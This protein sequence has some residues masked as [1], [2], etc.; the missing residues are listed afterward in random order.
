MGKHNFRFGGNYVQI[1]DNK[2]FGAYSYAVEALGNTDGESFSN[3]LTGN[4]VSFSVAIDPGN[5]FPG[6][7]IPLPV[8]PPSFSRS[9]RY[10]EW[11]LYGNDSWRFNQRL[12]FNFGLRYEYYGVQHN[13]QRPE[14]DAN[15]FYGAGST[16]QQ[17]IRN[18]QFLTTPNSPVGGL[19][20]P[21]RNNFAPRIGFAWDIFGD[22]KTSLRG[23]YGMAYE[24]NFGNVTFNVLFNPP[25]Y[26]VVA[27]T[28][29]SGTTAGDVPNLPIS[30]QNYGPFSGTGPARR[31]SP[32]SAR[33]VDQNIVNAYAH[34]WSASFERQLFNNTVA[35]VEYSGSAGRHLYSISD[36][37]RTGGGPVY[38]LGNTINAVGASTSRLNGVATS[39]NSRRNDGYSNYNALIASLDSSNFRNSGL[40][41]TARYTY[42]VSKDNLS[43]TFA[44]TGQTFFLGF[45][46]TFEPKA[47]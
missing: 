20:A 41:F 32:V 11:A 21:D 10:N 17:Q 47:D 42:S 26:G 43:S 3:F 33:A 23:G 16:F 24:R 13:A 5:R 6:A 36:I 25:N 22:G 45:T 8:G 7:L 4:L 27:L 40:T 34:F 29:N 12:T 46:D 30:I 9:N 38:G 44:E 2:T 18:G 39:A 37:N 1:R 14:L 15:F 28:A 31:F 19:W 35:S